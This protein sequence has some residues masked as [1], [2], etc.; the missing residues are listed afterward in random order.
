M[1]AADVSESVEA[2]AALPEEVVVDAGLPNTDEAAATEPDVGVT[3]AVGQQSQEE[4]A[5]APPSS[6]DAAPPA[7]DSAEG[8]SVVGE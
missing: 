3:A 2:A 4:E 7:V 1:T 5:S 8:A 6:E